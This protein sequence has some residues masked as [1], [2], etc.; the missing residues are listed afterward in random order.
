MADDTTEIHTEILQ[1]LQALPKYDVYHSEKYGLEEDKCE[2]GRYIKVEDV[3]EVIKF[4]EEF[5]KG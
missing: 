5:S 3:E 1:K 4:I 2:D